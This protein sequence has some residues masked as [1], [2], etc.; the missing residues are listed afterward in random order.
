MVQD[1]ERKK[2]GDGEKPK[3]GID[4]W[5][6]KIGYAREARGLRVMLPLYYGN[7]DRQQRDEERQMTESR[8]AEPIA[9]HIEDERCDAKARKNGAAGQGMQ[10]HRTAEDFKQGRG[11]AIESDRQK[12]QPRR[13][14]IEIEEI[15]EGLCQ[16]RDAQ[17]T[18][19]KQALQ[20]HGKA[21]ARIGRG[22]PASLA[23]D[24]LR[25]GEAD[26]D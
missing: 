20:Q 15:G 3:A 6:C 4:V 16:E 9:L 18:C 8:D 21:W 24:D 17:H 10:R 25:S 23:R 14:R 12:P 7:T 26:P 5:R 1:A 19:R 22:H 11:I 13:T 2:C